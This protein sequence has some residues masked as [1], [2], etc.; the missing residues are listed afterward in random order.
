MSDESIWRI[1]NVRHVSYLKRSLVSMSQLVNLGHVTLFIGDTW[2][3]TKGEMVLAH[4]SIEG[5]IYVIMEEQI[6]LE[7]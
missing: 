5:T 1:K 4:G 2:K 6:L 3:M 7:W